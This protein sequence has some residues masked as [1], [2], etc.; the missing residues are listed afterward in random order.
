[1]ATQQNPTDTCELVNPI[2][3]LIDY[4]LCFIDQ[5]F[6]LSTLK[7]CANNR[8]M[9]LFQGLRLILSFNL[10]LHSNK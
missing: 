3:K 5:G 10:H 7:Q 2:L 1:M 8:N 6:F 9:C 4:F